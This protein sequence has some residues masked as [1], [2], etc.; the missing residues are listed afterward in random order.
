MI[1]SLGT[2][3][4]L[5][6]FIAPQ[7]RAI[8]E[9]AQYYGQLIFLILLALIM[10]SFRIRSAY[11]FASLAVVMLIGAVGAEFAKIATGRRG[12]PFFVSYII[13]LVI[14]MIFALEAFTTVSC[15]AREGTN[16]LDTGHFR[17]PHRSHG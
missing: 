6:L 5:G 2:Q 10:Q 14:L 13:P 8:L 1:G 9:K 4:A 17:S 11:L 3:Y 12:M 15:V 16:S 7:Q